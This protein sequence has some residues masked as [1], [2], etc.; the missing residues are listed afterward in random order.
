MAVTRAGAGP[1]ERPASSTLPPAGTW[2][3]P[4]LSPPPREGAGAGAGQRRAVGDGSCSLRMRLGWRPLL[5]QAGAG[6]ARAAR[7]PSAPATTKVVVQAPL[8]EQAVLSLP[9][10]L[11]PPPS[12]QPL[13]EAAGG[14]ATNS[15]DDVGG[16]GGD[17]CRARP[18]RGCSL[19]ACSASEASRTSRR[20]LDELDRVDHLGRAG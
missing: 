16:G 3:V 18:L 19:G 2:Q 7:R 4:P 12:Q 9:T 15:A 11:P 5:P 13:L 20:F 1:R 8:E 14:E 10:V 6:W 17:A